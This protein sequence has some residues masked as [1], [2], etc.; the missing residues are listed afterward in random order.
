ML[1]DEALY[2]QDELAAI[3]RRLRLILARKGAVRGG[4][5]G[6]AACAVLLIASRLLPD[7]D[8]PDLLP[9]LLVMAGFVGGAA[10]GA[11]APLELLRW[12]GGPKA[13]WNSRTG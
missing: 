1:M 5:I 12:R 11:C 9:A 6:G 8:A 7:W 3:R 2:L 13:A 4:L 10:W